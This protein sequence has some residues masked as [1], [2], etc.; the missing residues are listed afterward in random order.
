MGTDGERTRSGLAYAFLDLVARHRPPVILMENVPGLLSSNRGADLGALLGILG[1]LGYGWAFRVLDARYFGVAQ[2]RRRVFIVAS[3][4]PDLP[5]EVLL[6]GASGAWDPAPRGKEGPRPPGE[7][8]GGPA[9]AGPAVSTLSVSGDGYH[10]GQDDD[11]SKLL[12]DGPDGPT[13]AAEPVG[14]VREPLAGEPGHGPVDRDGPDDLSPTLTAVPVG[15]KRGDAYHNAPIVPT[16]APGGRA[17][18]DPGRVREADGVAGRPHD[19]GPGALAAEAGGEEADQGGAGD[20]Q[21]G[22]GGGG[23]T[24][25][26]ET[27]HGHWREGD[28]AGTLA[29][30]GPRSFQQLAVEPTLSSQVNHGQWEEVDQ[31][32]TLMAHDAKAARQFVHEPEAY[33]GHGTNVGPMGALR[34]GNGNA[35]GGVP[36]IEVDAILDPDAASG[37]DGLALTPSPDAEGR[38][39]LRDAGLGIEAGDGVAPTL[40]ATAPPAVAYHDETLQSHRYSPDYMA[41]GDCIACGHVD[42]APIHRAYRE[43]DEA[44]LAELAAAG[45]MAFEWQQG[46]RDVPLTEQATGLTANTVPA[47]I[48]SPSVSG[49]QIDAVHVEDGLA[50]PLSTSL[51]TGVQKVLEDPEAGFAWQGGSNQDQVLTPDQVSPTLAFASSHHMGHHEPKVYLEG[52]A[53]PDTAAPITAWMQHGT[54]DQAG[55]HGQGPINT[56]VEGD[57]LAPTIAPG[58][59]GW[60]G[61]RG[62]GSDPAVVEDVA[63]AP[64]AGWPWCPRCELALDPATYAEAREATCPDCGGPWERDPVQYPEDLA[65]PVKARTFRGPDTD[66]AAGGSLV[67]EYAGALGAAQGGPDDNAAASSHLVPEAH[68]EQAATLNSPGGGGHR[69]DADQAAS[70][71]TGGTEEEDD[72]LLPKNLDSH[73][74]RVCGNGVVS[75]CTAWIGGGIAADLD[76]AALDGRLV[77]VLHTPLT[78]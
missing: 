44:R 74:Y 63:S 78:D 72:P 42:D 56:I 69:L 24:G 26:V 33:Q 11:G 31:A 6:G 46:S 39:R 28:Q 40:N 7:A 29:A 10:V 77:A 54:V 53:G 9:W 47:V 64:V 2:R 4:V 73:R 5:A 38:E 43:A 12:L 22:G 3:L 71:V 17:A 8:R 58:A 21:G 20:D 18:P 51:G 68:V 59:R 65:G 45:P 52:G 25:A 36:F 55:T 35:A 27:G 34:A 50:D 37:R 13:L 14:G 23:L 16:D 32:E 48:G 61:M 67:P 19:R 75:P 15:G 1:D 60:R 49:H 66:D 57:D 41:M 62:D 76:A 30:D 70:F